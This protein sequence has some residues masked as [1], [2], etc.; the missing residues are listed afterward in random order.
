[1]NNDLVTIV[2]VTY[3][4]EDLLEKTIWSVIN[5]NYKNI[6]YIIIDGAS[7]DKTVDIIKKYEDKI[8]YW[9]S[10]PDEGIYFAM[11]KAIDKASGKWINFM[12]AG[13]TF[14]DLDTINYIMHY[15]NDETD[16]IYGNCQIGTRIKKPHDLSEYSNVTSICHQTLFT[17]TQLMKQTLFDTRYRISADHNFILSM[18]QKNK[19]FQYID[20]PIA[21]FLPNGLSSTRIL[22][23]HIEGLSVLFANNVPESDILLSPWY[24]D[25]SKNIS[26]QQTNY[27]ST[28]KRQLEQ[29]SILKNA[30]QQ[31]VSYSTWKQ[32]LKKYKSY[33][34]MLSI[35]HELKN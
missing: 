23:M 1:M 32:P 13:D 7:T 28:L 10:E 27:I 11:N 20:K 16:L 8:D 15:T 9:I 5:Q 31:L 19:K 34:K 14:F 12:N 30:I 22:Q 3:N 26:K 18:F 17:K 6:E 24:I 2:T 25:M 29:L 35:F 21:N 4:A 33:K